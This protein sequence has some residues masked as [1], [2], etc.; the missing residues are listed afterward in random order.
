MFAVCTYDVTASG[1]G[2]ATMLFPLV[3][4]Q[5]VSFKHVEAFQR[6]IRH[7][8]PPGRANNVTHQTTSKQDQSSSSTNP[9]AGKHG[10][11][12]ISRGW[13]VDQRNPPRTAPDYAGSS[14]AGDS[15]LPTLCSGESCP[16]RTEKI[17]PWRARTLGQKSG[18][19]RFP[20]PLTVRSNLIDS[21]AAPLTRAP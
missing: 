16:G 1:T 7:Q 18:N 2:Q 3:G 19:A 14:R 13:C 15:M 20:A 12:I 21:P 6:S 17:S 4:P 8:C 11:S 5:I 10:V 9:A